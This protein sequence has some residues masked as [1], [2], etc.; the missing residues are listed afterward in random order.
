MD[1]TGFEAQVPGGTLVGRVSG[2]GEP[3]LLLHGGPGLGCDYL[4]DL[5]TELADG[6]LV[7]RYQ[8]RGLAPSTAGEPYDVATQ[9]RDVTLVLDS[10]G[11]DRA[12][13][14]G[15]S[16]G[17]HLLLH[18]LADHADR[19]VAAVVA[20]PLGGVGDGGEAEFAAEM[21]ARTP[22]EDVA[23]ME[24][25]D[26][27]AMAGEGSVEDALESLRLVW[28]AYYAD[29]A[30]APPMPPTP[31]SVEA[32]ARTWASLQELMPALA[33]RLTGCAVPTVFVHGGGSPMPLTASTDTA[34]AIG[35]AADVVVVPGTGHFIWYES[36]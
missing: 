31:M 7:A 12:V 30:S 23:R 13:I 21:S 14:I 22:A 3:V 9:A 29:P 5:V 27:R 17:G 26:A 24:E 19:V 8:Q 25:L 10:L 20:D 35:A 4:E 28:P 36:P 15:H 6:Y 18:V 16:W 34:E 1:A 32:Y 33:D 2:A 11:W